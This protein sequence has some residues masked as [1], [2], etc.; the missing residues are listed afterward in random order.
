LDLDQ[1][2]IAAVRRVEPLLELVWRDVAEV[3]V[4]AVV[5]ARVDP[6]EE[7][8]STSSAVWTR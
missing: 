3:A 2:L 7:S 1:W 5:I 6:A 4:Q 8:E